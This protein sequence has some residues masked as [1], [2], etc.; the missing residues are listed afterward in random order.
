MN[1]FTRTTINSFT[2]HYP[3]IYIFMDVIKKIQAT[4]YIKFRSLD[5]SAAVRRHEKEKMN[6]VSKKY[7]M[8]CRENITRSQFIRGVAYKYS[9]L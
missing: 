3:N 5:V 7:R 4:T 1:R 2:P 9:D 8:Y 6:F